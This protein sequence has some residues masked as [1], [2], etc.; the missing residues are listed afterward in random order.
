VVIAKAQAG[1]PALV[2]WAQQVVNGT[3][4]GAAPPALESL[5]LID[6]SCGS[7]LPAS[8]SVDSSGNGH[9]LLLVLDALQVGLIEV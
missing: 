2:S 7:S 3:E 4:S 9:P 1:N 5:E 6:D 8:S